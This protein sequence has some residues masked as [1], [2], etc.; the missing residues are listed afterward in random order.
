[1]IKLADRIYQHGYWAPCGDPF[2]GWPEGPLFV[3]V[4]GEAAPDGLPEDR[5]AVMWHY[6]N[7]SSLPLPEEHFKKLLAQAVYIAVTMQ[8]NPKVTFVACCA[9]GENRS[10]IMAAL[11]WMLLEGVEA[12]KVL[13]VTKLLRQPN[14]PSHILW[15][16]AF[17]EALV[18]YKELI[19]RA[20]QR[21]SGDKP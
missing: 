3:G 10:G 12:Q 4:F 14:S 5:A 2:L 7:D 6:F 9:A 18:D 1:M 15:N 11:G 19:D 16:P 20:R 13:D 8:R 21:V 17:R